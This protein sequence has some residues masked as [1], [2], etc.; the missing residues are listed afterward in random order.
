MNLHLTLRRLLGR[1]T[2]ILHRTARIE[3]GARIVNIGGPDERIVVGARSVIKGELLVFRHGGRIDIG[4]WCF[5]GEG[6]RIWS[7][8]SVTVGHR[9]MISHHVNI[10]DNLTHPLSAGARHAHF[11][12]ILTRGHPSEIDLGDQPVHI[13]DDAWIAA[14]TIVLRGVRVGRGA[15]VAAGAVVTRDV[16]A[17]SVVAG[18]PARVVRELPHEAPLPLA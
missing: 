3:A 12:E 18:N 10:L 9:V 1:P 5:V 13:E 4:Q 14:S 7:G 15:I 16:P 6:T 2:G 8:A 11:K 17:F